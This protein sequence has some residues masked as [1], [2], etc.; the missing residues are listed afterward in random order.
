MGIG[1]RGP[2]GGLCKLVRSLN[3]RTILEISVGDGTRAVAVLRALSAGGEQIHYAAIDQFE[4]SDGPVT[5]KEFHQS[6]RA[7][8]VRPQFFPGAIAPGLVQVS[9][10]IGAVDLVLIGAESEK[11]QTAAVLALLPRIIHRRSVVLHLDGDSWNRYEPAAPSVQRR[12]A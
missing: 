5:L 3:A 11:W 7:E 1:G 4:M 2:H 6:L 10:T 9:S 12:A 8:N